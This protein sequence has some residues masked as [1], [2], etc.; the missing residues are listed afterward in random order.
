MNYLLK[1]AFKFTIERLFLNKCV[2]KHHVNLNQRKRKL[3]REQSKKL[4][5]QLNN[6]DN[7]T[8]LLMKKEKEFILYKVLLK[9]LDMQRKL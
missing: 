8:K 4:L 5:T 3:K 7:F 6:G 2:L 1:I 9:K